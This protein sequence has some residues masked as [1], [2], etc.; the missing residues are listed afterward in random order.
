MALLISKGKVVN[1]VSGVAKLWVRV[2]A[3]WED[4]RSLTLAIIGHITILGH[5]CGPCLL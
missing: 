5:R 2:K 4:C 3:G 1:E